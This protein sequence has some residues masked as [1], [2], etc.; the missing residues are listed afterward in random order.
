MVNKYVMDESKPWE[1]RYK[2]LEAHH[3]EET[4]A[5]LARIDTLKAKLEYGVCKMH[6]KAKSIDGYCEMC[7]WER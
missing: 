1:D 2:E 4:S 7:D 5:L 3:I 6:N